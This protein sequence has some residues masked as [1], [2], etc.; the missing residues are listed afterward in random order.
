MGVA[1]HRHDKPGGG[2]SGH[3][4][5]HEVLIDDIGAVDLG[6][7]LGHFAQGMDAGLGEE[8][9]EAKTHAVLLLEVIFV[10][11]AQR[12]HLGHVHL[13]IGGQH[14]GGV[15][16]IF[17]A[18]RDGL[19]QAGHFHPF[20]ARGILGRGRG[21]G[22][23]CG[24]RCGGLRGG[25]GLHHIFLHDPTV[26]AGAC[27]LSGVDAFFGHH[28]LRRG[29][30]GDIFAC[31]GGGG[32]RGGGCG[33]GGGHS[34]DSAADH[35]ELA[36]G[37]HGCAFGG[38]DFAQDTG[39]G[40]WHLD[41]DLVGFKFAEH[42][43]LRHGVADFLEPCGNRRLGHAFAERGDHDIDGGAGG[44]FGGGGSGG[45]GCAFAERG[46]KRV[47]ADGFTLGRDDGAKDAS[48]GAWHFDRDL[49]GLKFAE[50][51]VLGDRLA[52][53]LE[54]CGHRRFGDAF[55][56]RGHADFDRHGRYPSIVSASF[57]S[58]VCWDLCMLAKPVAGEAEA[59]RPA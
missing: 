19:A 28:L 16:R 58:A 11:V 51:F 38:D 25:G 6:I 1:D 29:G 2:T 33:R 52:G 12:H 15:L 40:A 36:I 21:A 22:G 49:V 37:L 17:Q 35:G 59:A 27:D 20:F 43:I 24:G 14:R 7:H 32:R 10:G 30:M 4:H 45:C 55:A 57:T 54:P 34:G 44:R 48:G 9:H 46:Q 23:G 13:V 39:S 31:A 53:F 3:A 42:F 18:A 5:M 47:D 26:A 56:Q 41:R 50:H 8:G